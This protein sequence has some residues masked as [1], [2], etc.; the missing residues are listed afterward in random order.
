MNLAMCW[1]KGPWAFEKSNLFVSAARLRAVRRALH[2]GLHVQAGLSSADPFP[3]GS[4]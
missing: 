3:H 1:A 2:Y 4:R